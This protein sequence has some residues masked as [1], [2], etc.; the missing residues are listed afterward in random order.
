MLMINLITLYLLSV[1][2]ATVFCAVQIRTLSGSSYVKTS[3]LLCF[4]VC[5]YILGYT[6]ELNST[7][8]SQIMFWNRI[9]YIGIPFVSALWLTI[10]LMYT[11]HFTDHRKVLLAAIYGVPVVTM[12]LR[13][14][15]E[16]HHLYFS[17]VRYIEELGGLILVKQMGPWMYVQ[18][19]HSALMVLLSMGLFIYNSTK[20]AQ[21]PMGKIVLIVV[22]SVAA[23]SGLFLSQFKLFGVQ[24]DYMALCLPVTCITVIT[25]ISRYDLLEIKSIARSKVFE[26]SKD[27]ILLLNHQGRVLDYND[28]AK[29]LFAQANIPL[30][31]G[32]FPALPRHASD[33]LDSL[34]HRELSVAKL[35]I[36]DKDYYFNIS[37]EPICSYTILLGWIK[38]I[39]DI[40]ELCRLNEELNRQAMTDELS[41]LSNRRAF[42]K[43]G[44]EFILDAEAHSTSLHL[45]MLDLDHFKNVNDEYGHP[46]GDLVILEFSKILK[47]HFGANNLVARLGGEEF[48]V[49]LSGLSDDAALQQIRDFLESARQHV[50][51][52][53]GKQF[54]VTTSIGVTKGQPGQTLESMLRTVDKALYQS[55]DQG[56]DL[57]TVL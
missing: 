28:S 53:F 6:M 3:L 9:E 10:S 39:H 45:L 56:R 8:P 33:F 55:K 30:N 49:L 46:A 44:R 5:F 32:T 43:R 36:H 24:I 12:V 20:S 42:M 17:S 57:I 25:A 18:T 35:C 11:G 29:R 2:V 16:Y 50:Y 52:Y 51:E 1:T 4:A 47:H 54:H 41:V 40:T 37:T 34:K 19:Y 23:V 31:T 14:T 13:F 15:N 7:I 22:A 26:A 48:V 27:A 38:T 21:K